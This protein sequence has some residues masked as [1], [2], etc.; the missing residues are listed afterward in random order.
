MVQIATEG[1]EMGSTTKNKVKTIEK[2]IGQQKQAVPKRSQE[3]DDAM[4]RN[5][6]QLT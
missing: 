3:K 5:L 6:W 1:V 4:D 2:S